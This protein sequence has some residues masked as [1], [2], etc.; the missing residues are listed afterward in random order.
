MANRRCKYPACPAPHKG[1][2]WCRKHYERWKKHGSPDGLVPEPDLPGERWR[3]V[4]GTGGCYT[5][6]DFG[7]VRSYKLDWCLGRLLKPSIG[8]HGYPCVNI[9]IPGKVAPHPVH[10]LLAAAFLGP[11]P[12]GKEVR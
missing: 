4:P 11:R 8:S 2:G 10:I 9:E 7:R 6:S 1:Y 12:P 5:V 3:P